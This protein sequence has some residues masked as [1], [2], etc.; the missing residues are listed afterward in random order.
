[1]SVFADSIA[2][3]SGLITADPRTFTAAEAR[4]RI[5]LVVDVTPMPGCTDATAGGRRRLDLQRT[6]GDERDALRRDMAN[7]FRTTHTERRRKAI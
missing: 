5:Q 7:G 1:M 3:R 2:E 4:E 6:D